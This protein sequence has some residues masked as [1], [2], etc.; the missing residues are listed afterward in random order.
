MG[1]PSSSPTHR[2]LNRSS[3]ALASSSSRP[4]SLPWQESLLG[5]GRQQFRTSLRGR[6]RARR[7]RRVSVACTGEVP[8][9]N[10]GFHHWVRGMGAA[11]P[12]WQSQRG[13]SDVCAVEQAVADV[14]AAG[15]SAQNRGGGLAAPLLLNAKS[16]DGQALIRQLHSGGRKPCPPRGRPIPCEEPPER[17][18]AVPPSRGGEASRRIESRRLRQRSPGRHPFPP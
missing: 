13:R 16:F 12:S 1:C 3:R 7:D 8:V 5:W 9:G 10:F 11:R 2:D 17:V 4:C 18:P 6:A 15:T 14:V